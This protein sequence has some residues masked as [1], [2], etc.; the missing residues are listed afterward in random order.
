M[1]KSKQTC[2]KDCR[3]ILYDKHVHFPW[4]SL[5]ESKPR[6]A[7]YR[8]IKFCVESGILA[9]AEFAGSVM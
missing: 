3:E 1:S 7:A 8:G 9:K 2:P 5:A 6:N 4:G